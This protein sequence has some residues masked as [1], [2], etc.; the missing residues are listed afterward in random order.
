MTTLDGA[1]LARLHQR[2]AEAIRVTVEQNARPLYRAARGIGCSH[3]EAED[4]VQDVFATFLETL[5]HFEGRSAVRTWLFGILHRKKLERYRQAARDDQHDPIDEVFE[6][7]FD[8]RGNWI[9]PPLEL[10]RLAASSEARDAIQA[11]LDQLPGLQRH[12]FVLREIEE[13]DAREVS[14]ILGK[15]VTHVG[16]LFHRA[17]MRLRQCLE[18]HGWG[19][20]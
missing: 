12:A 1:F 10:D 2:D 4:L 19:Q 18:A 8:V 15:T 11:C 5:D 6:S 3:P 13:R 7:C 20:R 16:V 9:R 17:R 14:N